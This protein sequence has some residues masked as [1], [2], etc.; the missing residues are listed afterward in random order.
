LVKPSYVSNEADKDA[1]VI[2]IEETEEEKEN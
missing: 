1:E 2:E